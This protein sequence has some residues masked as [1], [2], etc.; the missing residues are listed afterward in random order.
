MTCRLSP[1]A[2]SHWI[3]FEVIQGPHGRPHRVLAYAQGVEQTGFVAGGLVYD[4]TLRNLERK[5]D[6]TAT[7]IPHEVRSAHAGTRGARSSPC[8]IA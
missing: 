8:A 5:G 1:W 6:D 3:R 7:H 2:S 4:A